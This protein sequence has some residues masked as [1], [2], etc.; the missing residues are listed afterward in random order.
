MCRWK[1]KPL[2]SLLTIQSPHIV[3]DVDCKARGD[4]VG[5]IGDVNTTVEGY[6]CQN[7]DSNFPHP[8][9]YNVGNHNKCRNP[10]A[11]QDDIWCYTTNLFHR[12]DYCSV[13]TCGLREAY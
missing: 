1:A 6:T 11:L 12:W 3:W 2:Q 4:G 9:E 5:Y 10:D 8:H 13:R 7:W